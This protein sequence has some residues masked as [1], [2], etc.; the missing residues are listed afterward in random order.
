MASKLEAARIA[1]TAGE[2]VIIANGRDAG[3]PGPDRRRRRRSARCSSPRPGH[4]SCK[5]WIGFTAQPRGTLIARRRRPQGGRK[6]GTQ[7]AGDRHRRRPGRFQQR[8][9]RRPARR[10]RRHEFARGLSN[11]SAAEA[12]ADQGPEDRADRRASWATARTKK[13]FIATTWRLTKHS[14]GGS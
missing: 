9:R 13:S 12:T 14:A 6:E 3:Q 4:P 2:N 8:G 1:T 10:R 5:R 11:Y 7:P